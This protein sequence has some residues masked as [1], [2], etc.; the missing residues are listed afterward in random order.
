MTTT[1]TITGNAQVSRHDAGT[2]DAILLIV[3]KDATVEQGGAPP[4][5]APPPPAP[6][7]AGWSATHKRGD[8]TVAGDHRNIAYGTSG[9]LQALSA[10]AHTNDGDYYAEVWLF[11]G[12]DVPLVGLSGFSNPTDWPGKAADEYTLYSYNGKK[13]NGGVQ[14]AYAAPFFAEEAPVCIG[15]RNNYGAVSFSIDGT[16]YPVAFNVGSAPLRLVFGSATSA[17]NLLCASVNVG[18]GRFL[19][20]PAGVQGWERTPEPTDPIFY[21]DHFMAQLHCILRPNASGVWYIQNDSDHAPRGISGVS[22]NANGL[23]LSFAKTYAKAGTIQV[24]SDDNFARKVMGHGNL[25]LSGS[26]IVLTKAD[27]SPLNPSDVYTATPGLIPGDGNLWINVT[28]WE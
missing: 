27:G 21:G 28:M 5:P 15:I 7:L 23:Q 1:I 16:Q 25:G 26:S 20:A 4:P 3:D 2:R 11:N 9:F 14:T 6:S 22:Q 19:H 13:C 12:G 17:S 24:T 8:V 18:Q 10:I